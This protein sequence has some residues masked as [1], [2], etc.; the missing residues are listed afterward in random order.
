MKRA[1]AIWLALMLAGCASQAPAPPNLVPAERLALAV[2]PGRSTMQ[3]VQ[4]VLGPA[5][6]VRFDSGYQVWLYLYPPA[7]PLPAAPGEPPEYAEF[8]ILFGPDGVVA[9]TRRR[10]PSAAIRMKGT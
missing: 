4:A 6:S 1:L 7:H 2:A 10:E 5:T 8:V 9:K 3:Q